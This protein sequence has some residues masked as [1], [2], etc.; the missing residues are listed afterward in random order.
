MMG[1]LGICKWRIFPVDVESGEAPSL[2]H[3]PKSHIEVLTP[4]PMVPLLPSPEASLSLVLTYAGR[5]LPSPVEPLLYTDL[6]VPSP[7]VGH[8]FPDGFPDP[9][10]SFHILKASRIFF[11]SAVG[12]LCFRKFFG[13]YLALDF[14]ESC[15][16]C[17]DWIFAAVSPV[18]LGLDAFGFL[19]A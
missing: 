3:F 13:D 8:G 15:P 12:G 11:G 19:V 14:R 7:V 2:F 17:C 5:P 6:A 18:G 9:G 4:S 16:A 1:A 10:G